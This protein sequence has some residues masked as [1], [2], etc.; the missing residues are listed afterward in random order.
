MKLAIIG[1]AGARTPLLVN[2]L[3]QSDLPI[4]EIRLFDP[5]QGHLAIMANL[6]RK[7]CGGVSLTTATH[8][9]EA[10][11]GADFVF[12]SIRVGGIAARAHDEATALSHGIV[13]QET[14]GPGGFA[15]AM[16]TVPHVVAYA[17]EIQ[18]LAPD[19]WI[20][21]FTNPVGIVTQAVRTATGARIIG[22]CDTPTELYEEVCHALD[23]PSAESHVDYFGLNHLGWIREV[24]YRGIPQIHRLWEEPERL[25]R[26]YRTSLFSEDFLRELR[27]LPTEYVYYYYRAADAYANVARTGTSRAQVIEGLNQRLFAELAN[28]S[29]DSVGIYERYI[30]ARDAGYMQIESGRAD[31]RPKSPWS[32]VTGYDK[33][34]LNTVRAIHFNSNAIIPLNVDNRG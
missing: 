12:I 25:S 10:V 15:K 16:R 28:G 32:E 9:A 20:I 6:A 19:A 2:G 1:A 30:A 14:V 5:D 33:I 4:R 11:A 34:A 31:P 27:L 17:R 13:G 23:V 24:Y 22:I 21:N 3:T 29:Q 7:R 26:V 18:A 8:A